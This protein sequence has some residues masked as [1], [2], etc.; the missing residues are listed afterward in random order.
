M[1]RKPFSWTAPVLG[2]E[3]YGLGSKSRGLGLLVAASLHIK[4]FGVI[5][6]MT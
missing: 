5:R 6:L 4:L 2:L 1:G 3:V